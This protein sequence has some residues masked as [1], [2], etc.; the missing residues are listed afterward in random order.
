[1][2]IATVNPTLS[3][4]SIHIP[5]LAE[6]DV[7]IVNLDPFVGS[8][9]YPIR[10]TV[11]GNFRALCYRTSFISTLPSITYTSDFTSIATGTSFLLGQDEQSFFLLFCLSHTDQVCTLYPSSEGMVLNSV[12][13]D[14]REASRSRHAMLA[15]RGHDLDRLIH[16]TLELSL[17][18][19]GDI[20][21]PLNKKSTL[22]PW[23]EDLCWT[24]GTIRPHAVSRERIIRDLRRLSK[25]HLQIHTVVIEEGWQEL[26][27]N[28]NEKRK[29]A[30]LN[31]F[32]ADKIRFPEGLKGL[33][34]A[35]FS[36]NIK[37]IGITHPLMGG[38]DGIHPQ[39]AKKYDLAPD[40]LGRYFLGY[41]LGRTFQFY[42]DYY[43]SLKKSGVSFV[44][45]SDQ[46]SPQFFL[47]KGTSITGLY[48][49]LQI[50]T[51]AAASIHFN[52]VSFN[53]D[54]LRN[55]N[56]FYWTTS[57]VA[58]VTPNDTPRTKQER[59]KRIRDGLLNSLWLQHLMLPEFAGWP[60]GIAIKDAFAVCLGCSGPIQTIGHGTTSKDLKV[61][62]YA[63]LPSGKT[64]KAE[65]PLTLASE[66][67]FCDPLEEDKLFTAF[68][69]QRHTSIA[70][71][72]H[73]NDRAGTLNSLVT[74]EEFP[75]LH[76][77]QAFA[78]H[79]LQMG[80]LGIVKR[81]ETI[82]IYLKKHEG[83]ILTLAPVI[84]GIAILGNPHFYIMAACLNK[85]S[86][87]EDSIH[88]QSEVA[89]PLLIYS[90]RE[91]L[92]V[93]RDNLVVPWDYDSR[94]FLLLIEG[95]RETEEGSCFY[96]VTFE[97]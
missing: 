35:L 83:E 31:S 16:K 69:A 53:T 60:S 87:G 55:E 54:C 24:S 80:F 46:G 13:D 45:I 42:H 36:L 77:A 62:R 43:S 17:E 58:R 15:L 30:A 29:S 5:L 41:D 38:P 27:P 49:N 97:A 18:L 56:L 66:S 12:S 86:T 2:S 34:E 6:D 85:I 79:S 63:V 39:L 73:L 96:T 57:S 64:L 40:H 74:P 1:M 72:F 4:A 32:E 21:K 59:A 82:P 91:I 14:S 3:S 93:R 78:V 88:I 81:E 50:A 20:G 48:K 10:C 28:P 23:I 51:Q 95:E 37:Q 19:T 65:K 76:Q 52:A 9:T 94:T 26:A 75:H 90:E 71:F 25:T 8:C 7:L 84:H 47:Q 70:V 68:T 11:A 33:T 61:L 89:A 44:R 92:E 67:V 22:P